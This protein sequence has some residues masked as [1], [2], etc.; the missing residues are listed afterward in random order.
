M[1][2]IL[3]YTHI[4]EELNHDIS[5]LMDDWH[6]LVNKAKTMGLDIRFTPDGPTLELY[7]HDDY[8]DTLLVDKHALRI[9]A[10]TIEAFGCD[11]CR[12]LRNIEPASYVGGGDDEFKAFIQRARDNKQFLHFCYNDDGDKCFEVVECCP[13]CGYKFTEKDYDSYN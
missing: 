8:S 3:P 13:R 9:D 2:R 5:E 11:Y 6:A 7:F 10:P 1:G 4:S 12:D